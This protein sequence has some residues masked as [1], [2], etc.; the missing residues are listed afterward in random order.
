MPRWEM[1]VTPSG[2]TCRSEDQTVNPPYSFG[3][4]FS[5]ANRCCLNGEIPLLRSKPAS[6]CHGANR[7]CLKC[8]RQT[9][10]VVRPQDGLRTAGWHRQDEGQKEGLRHHQTFSAPERAIVSNGWC[11]GNYHG[12]R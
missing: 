11:F 6:H 2:T 9:R 7:I 8:R 5:S 12:L 4:L 1:T 3:R 10:L